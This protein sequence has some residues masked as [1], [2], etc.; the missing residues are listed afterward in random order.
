MHNYCIYILQGKR[1]NE[2]RVKMKMFLMIFVCVLFFCA[3]PVAAEETESML[4]KQIATDDVWVENLEGETEVYYEFSI[5]SPG[6]V[7]CTMRSFSATGRFQ[8]LNQDLTHEYH[9]FGIG[10]SP[11]AP[12]TKKADK[13]LEAGT[14]R[15]HVSPLW[16]AW[17]GRFSLKVK[18]TPAN[19]NEAEPN[20]SFDTAMPLQP[21]QLVTGLIS[22]DDAMDFYKITVSSPQTVSFILSYN[23]LSKDISF[24]NGD[25]L[26]LKEHRWQSVNCEY[27]YEVQPG[28]YYFKV[29]NYNR[30]IYSI[31][32]HTKQYVS[33][34][35]FNSKKAVL[36]KGQVFNPL[37][38]V[39]PADATNK[40]LTWSSSN[41]SVAKVDASG[42]VKAVGVGST[43]IT[44]TST[45]GTQKSATCFVIVKPGKAKL[46]KAKLYRY[47]KCVIEMKTSTQKGVS[48][49]QFAWSTSKKFKKKKSLVTSYVTAT[50]PTLKKKKR[51]YVRVRAYY[52]TG[53]EKYYGE[54]SNINSVKTK[55]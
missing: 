23:G 2:M 13:Y 40:G 41:T 50:T 20:N 1:G 36:K 51:Y 39:L 25:L 52:S 44:A 28:T 33:S 21:E 54:W 5:S 22:E 11:T 32:Y 6:Y 31:K 48:G 37:Q 12:D 29:S 49:Y 15:I 34:V 4:I 47:N 38:S 16:N 55:K 19:N 53:S 35:N 14:Y 18:H 10:G 42:N 43:N 26:C 27:E 3:S 45:D 9:E 8:L 17:N 46:K 30:G 7:E 24:W